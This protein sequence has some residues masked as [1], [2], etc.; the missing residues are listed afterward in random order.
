[1]LKMYTNVVCW[2]RIVVRTRPKVKLKLEFSKKQR[3]LNS[4]YYLIVELWNQMGVDVQMERKLYM[5]F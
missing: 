3:L 5:I 2:I 1:M 4:P